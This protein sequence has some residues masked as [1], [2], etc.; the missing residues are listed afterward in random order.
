MMNKKQQEQAPFVLIGRKTYTLYKRS[1]KEES[2]WWFRIQRLGKRLPMSTG[3]ADAAAACEIV[4]KIASEIVAGTWTGAS[5]LVRRRGGRL[6]T[7]GEVLKLADA[8]NGRRLVELVK[9]VS[10]VEV[11]GPLL[12]L[13]GWRPSPATP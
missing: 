12:Q 5:E 13:P 6:A 4:K 9:V 7:L 2:P 8:E 1:E 10:V 11:G 3:T